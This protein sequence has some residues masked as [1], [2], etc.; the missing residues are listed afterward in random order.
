MCA[1]VAEAAPALR[2]RTPARPAGG[3]CG[4]A[5]ACRTRE[6]LINA[7]IAAVAAAEVSVDYIAS[8][9]RPAYMTDEDFKELQSW[10]VMENM[11]AWATKVAQANEALARVVPFQPGLAALLPFKPDAN[12]R[13]T[14][15]VIID[16]LRAA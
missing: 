2:P 6:D 3:S 14:H 10:L 13:G 15:D 11:K 12:N 8:V 1:S 5:R 16:A 7:A 4:Q 9:G